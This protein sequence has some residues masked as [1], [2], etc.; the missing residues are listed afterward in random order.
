MSSNVNLFRKIKLSTK[1]GISFS[2]LALII[3]FTVLINTSQIQSAAEVSNRMT[4]LREPTA[5]ASLEILSGINHALAALRG[6]MLLGKDSF[7][8]E[9]NQ[10]WTQEIWPAI[11]TLKKMSINWTNPDNIKRLRQ[12]EQLLPEF[13][14]FQNEI[15]SIA[16]S[17]ENIPALRMLFEDAAPQAS[18]MVNSITK[19]IDEEAKAPATEERKA[20]LGMMADVRGTTGL[21]LAN[22]RA[23]LLAGDPQY[24][25]AYEQLWAKNERRFREL[26][27]NSALLTTTQKSAFKAL[28]E[29]RE[30]FS[31]LP[32]EMMALRAADDWN[33]ANHW[34]AT[35]AAPLGKTLS[36]TLQQMS[37][38]QKTLLDLDAAQIQKKSKDLVTLSWVLLSFGVLTAG[39]LGFFITRSVLSQLGEDPARLKEVVTAI[40]NDDL[41]MNLN[42]REPATG[43]FADMQVMQKSLRQRIETDRIA[44][45]ESG[46]ILQALDNVHS[47]VMIAN[48]ELQIIYMNDAIKKLFQSAEVDIHQDLP[49]FD[50]QSPLNSPIDI[51]YKDQAN[52]KSFL[53]HLGTSHTTTLRLGRSTF[54]LVTNPVFDDNQTRLGTV[55]EWTDRTQELAIEQ[56]VQKVVDSALAG[57]LSNRISISGNDS[58]FERLSLSVNQLVSVAQHVIDDTGRVLGAMS[59]G[60][61][62]ETIEGNYDGSFDHLKQNANTTI[63]KLTDVVGSIQATAGS[64]KTGADEISQGNLDLSHRTEQQAEK[65]EETATSLEQITSAVKQNAKNADLA[66]QFAQKAREQAEQGGIA[67]SKAV[68]AMQKINASSDQISDIISVIDEIAFQTN[69]LALNAAV[70]AARAGDGGRGFAVVAN[71]VRNLAGRSATAAKEIKEL[72]EDSSRKVNEGSLL[73]NDS[74]TTLE[75]IISGIEKVTEV[76]GEIATANQQQAVGVAEVNAAVTQ[77]DEFTQHNAALVE[78]AAAAS[79]SLGE[80][81]DD[82]NQMMAFFEVQKNHR[83]PKTNRNG[84]TAPRIVDQRPSEHRVQTSIRLSHRASLRPRAASFEEKEKTDWLEF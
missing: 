19:M 13:Q 28:V 41:D 24:H 39:L 53:E 54:K 58:F 6:W 65:L 16:Q 59:T 31:P 45:D 40:A 1:L 64:V 17:P 14:K 82:L 69:L 38:N 46:R 47:N 60:D 66:H 5:R 76:M 78:Q 70:E 73:V 26:S 57:D 74:G 37:E 3:A 72:I 12:L 29:A 48:T 18:I 32:K 55:I 84:H 77:M 51:F 22:I 8:T 34:L 80:K 81:A 62:T 83:R 42:T 75:G 44:L 27:N 21:A 36:I 50:V 20:L 10:A 35:Q 71:E 79:E 23:F 61:L 4:Q 63:K 7:K 68:S 25:T 49:H 2:V 52:P 33:I 9:R 30:K 43:I 56:E 67:V 15:E 11:E